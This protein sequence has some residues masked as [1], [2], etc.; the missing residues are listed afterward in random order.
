MKIN[1][2]YDKLLPTLIKY[3]PRLDDEFKDKRVTVEIKQYRKARSLDQ[4]ALMW[5]ILDKMAKSLTT[6]TQE[7]YEQMIR[8]YGVSGII[9]LIKDS[10]NYEQILKTQK[11]YDVL[12]DRNV[13]IYVGSSEYDSKQ[14]TVLIDG[15]L[16]ECEQMQLDVSYES[17]ELKSLMEGLKW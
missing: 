14:M 5:V 10:A 4:N 8:S 11:F 16:S 13:R 7:V 3:M 17:K 12:D 9:G 2:N 1:T 6:T 15:I